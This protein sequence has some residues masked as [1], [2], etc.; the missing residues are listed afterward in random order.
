MNL[1]SLQDV[2]INVDKYYVTVD[3]HSVLKLLSTEIHKDIPL[4]GN[5]V[6]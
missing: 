3:C 6:Y 2:V 1:K 5:Q 4:F